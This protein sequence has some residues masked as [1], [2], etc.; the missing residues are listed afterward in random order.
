MQTLITPLLSNSLIALFADNHKEHSEKTNGLVQIQR[1]RSPL[2]ALGG[3][4]VL[5]YVL[6][7]WSMHYQNK[8]F[9]KIIQ[10]FTNTL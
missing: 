10:G 5:K 3:G 1:G 6:Q 2:Q 8:S 4:G 7:I 9:V